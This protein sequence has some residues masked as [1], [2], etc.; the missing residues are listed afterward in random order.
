MGV[1]SSV[2]QR[3]SQ[4]RPIALP[5]EVFEHGSLLASCNSRDIGLGGVFLSL[6]DNELSKDQEV[7]LFFSLGEGNP[8]RYKLN[9][10]VVRA[11]DAGAGLLF[12]D[13]DTNAFRALQEIMRYSASVESV[14]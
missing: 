11:A 10:K 8:T 12:K 1:L 13:F 3:W 6:A 2:E 5:V 9:A 14:D 7:E 4:R